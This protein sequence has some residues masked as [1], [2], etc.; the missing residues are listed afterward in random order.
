MPQE[1]ISRPASGG[2]INI[3]RGVYI[4]EQVDVFTDTVA[5][6]I[7]NLL[8]IRSIM[9][10]PGGTHSVFTH[11]SWAKRELQC[12]FLGKKAIIYTSKLGTT[13]FLPITIFFWENLK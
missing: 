12:I 1:H 3:A 9:G 13:I 11:T 10:C 8:D 7:L 4:A 6:A 2:C 5:M